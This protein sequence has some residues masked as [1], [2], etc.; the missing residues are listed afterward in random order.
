MIHWYDLVSGIHL[1]YEAYIEEQNWT[2]T[3]KNVIFGTVCVVSFAGVASVN[4]H[5][6]A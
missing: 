3:K 5:Q 2:L 1:E 6:L 4:V